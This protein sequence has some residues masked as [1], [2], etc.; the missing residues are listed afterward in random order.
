MVRSDPSLIFLVRLRTIAVAISSSRKLPREPPSPSANS[1]LSRSSRFAYRSS[2]PATLISPPI[3]I[4]SRLN[5]NEDR[6]APATWR[7]SRRDSRDTHEE[8][9]G[10]GR[11]LNEKME[12]CW[13]ATEQREKKEREIRAAERTGARG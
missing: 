12:T 13:N 8:K 1:F 7:D 11:L 5:E 2:G 4:S 10:R 3:R 6:Y 9:R